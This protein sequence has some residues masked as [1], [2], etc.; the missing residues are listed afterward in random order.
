MAAHKL[1]LTLGFGGP[2]RLGI[3]L[4]DRGRVIDEGPRAL[5]VRLCP[6]MKNF[7]VRPDRCAAVA[8]SWPKPPMEQT[9]NLG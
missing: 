1:P 4:E 6:A 8:L 9:R 3:P 7:A 5:S 2:V